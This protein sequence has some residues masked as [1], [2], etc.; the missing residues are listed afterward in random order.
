LLSTYA[1]VPDDAAFEVALDNDA[2]VAILG[3]YSID[4]VVV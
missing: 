4:E 1:D 2:S 3:F